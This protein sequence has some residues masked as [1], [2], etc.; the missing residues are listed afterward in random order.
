V[1]TAYRAA[2]LADAPVALWDMQDAAPTTPTIVQKAIA[3]S[4]V[5][6][7]SHSVTLPGAPTAGNLV[8][9][10]W[11]GTTSQSMSMVGS[12]WTTVG[13]VGGTQVGGSKL[14]VFRRTVAGG[15]SA[16]YTTTATTSNPTVLAAWEISGHSTTT[17]VQDF[18]SLEDASPN[19][20]VTTSVR[21]SV[22]ALGGTGGSARGSVVPPSG[23]TEDGD[24]ATAGGGLLALEVAHVAL[25]DPGDLGADWACPN[26]DPV[27]FQLMVNPAEQVIADAGSGGNPGSC[28]G[29]HVLRVLGPMGDDYAIGLRNGTGVVSVPSAA[30]LNI[31]GD[32]TIEFWILVHGV[33][34]LGS[35]ISKGNFALSPTPYSLNF[36]LSPQLG[37]RQRDAGGAS[38]N[39]ASTS[40]YNTAGTW[41]HVVVTRVGS[42]GA[43][44]FY[45]NGASAGSGTVTH[46][47]PTSDTTAVSIPG[48]GDNDIAYFALYNVA[49]TSGQ[50]TT[51]YDARGDM[52][53]RV[54]QLQLEAALSRLGSER[55]TQVVAELG[56]GGTQVALVTQAIVE[57]AESLAPHGLITQV[58]LEVARSTIG[59]HLVTQLL[60]EGGLSHVGLARLTAALAEVAT[61]VPAVARLTQAAAEGAISPGSTARA[62]ALV[63]EVARSAIAGA[64]ASQVIA[65]AAAAPPAH[66]RLTSA[67]ALAGY[68]AVAHGRLSQVVLEVAI[69]PV[70]VEGPW[71]YVVWVT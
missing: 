20:L 31:V 27:A 17:P 64:L 14:T 24:A 59:G 43:I 12:G 69:S 16:T 4:A 53:Q 39:V 36:N 26:D 35:I 34:G 7:T 70:V 54:T 58:V 51:H 48:A 10:F 50:V 63:L 68:Q 56:T 67:L 55:L 33:A 9:I 37:F 15:E 61:K 21:Q 22:L 5:D 32:L 8:V 38:N 3:A 57:L 18:A 49:L 1:T 66:G 6:A 28:A 60:A 19:R 46:N 45:L 25:A 65:E 52:G 11:M 47:P 40:A 13:V 71:S 30:S 41:Q 29:G 23:W 2:V 62:T 44:A 42:T